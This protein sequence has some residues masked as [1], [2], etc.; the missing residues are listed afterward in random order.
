M[1]FDDYTVRTDAVETALEVSKT[2]TSAARLTWNEEAGY[3]YQVEYSGD[4]LSWQT[5]PAGASHTGTL[6]QSTSFTDA[7]TVVPAS[8]FYRIKRS[9]P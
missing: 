9:Y 1:L 5:D 4:C 7:T 8:R 6:T 3:T 2:G